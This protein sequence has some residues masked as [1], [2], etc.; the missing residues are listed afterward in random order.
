MRNC[1]ENL[2][3]R[4]CLLVGRVARLV[5][6]RGDGT[7]F[8]FGAELLTGGLLL[9]PSIATA[10]PF[11]VCAHVTRDEFDERVRTYEMMREAGFT[12]VRSDFDWR[13]C[14]RAKDAPFDFST[15]DRVVDDAA[16]YGV[17]VLPILHGTPQWAQ[18]VNAHLD[19][20]RKFVRET[21]RHFRGRIPVYEIWNEENADSFW[22]DPDP[23]KY[24]VAL[25][26]AY[27]EV[28]AVDPSA[29]VAFGGTAGCAWDYIEKAVRAGAKDC[30]DIVNVHPYRHPHPPEPGLTEDLNA[31]KSMM[32]RN[33][34]ADRPIWI[35]ELG[36]PTHRATVPDVP[37]FRAA[38]KIARPERPLWRAA[39]VNIE[40]PG[41]AADLF[42]DAVREA[43]P[44]GSS[45]VGVTSDELN[46]R[47]PKGDFDLVVYPIG[48]SYPDDTVDAVAEFVR[49]GGTLAAIGGYPLYYP[50][51]K[52]KHAGS[53]PQGARKACAARER[54]R[55]GVEAWWHNKAMPKSAQMF[56]SADA[57]KVGLAVD[58]AGLAATRFFS[59]RLLKGAD[60]L[61]PL[62]VGKD[63][64]GGAAIGACV[65]L[66]DSD[67]KGRIFVSSRGQS[68]Y[69][70]ST[71]AQQANYT[72]TAIR[73]A[74]RQ[75]VEKYFIYEFRAVE[76]DPHDSEHHF[77]IVHRDFT[78][79]PA[80]EACR[81]YI[82]GR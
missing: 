14:Q 67:M 11:G 10:S 54:L 50:C 35:T 73:S 37:V 59:A 56:P 43:L 42:A 34:I 47:L 24:A 2:L 16:T 78:P 60:R 63:K 3:Y 30:F 41:A 25:K 27:E 65:Y 76:R 62:L 5:C 80:Y 75:G 69:G 1:R 32:S 79:K 48:E 38:L 64:T 17:T 71:E 51:R 28:K 36:W 68:A 9:V 70:S 31:L 33:G 12:D 46:A 61:V 39:Y 44:S 13:H 19:E 57:K 77:G 53:S 4:F 7:G 8:D 29:R 20:W 82:Q 74:L 45:C 55:I 72:V 23:A 66:F 18:P 81:D 21:A 6:V 22:K 52:G 26:A 49:Q 15:Y 58:P 40:L